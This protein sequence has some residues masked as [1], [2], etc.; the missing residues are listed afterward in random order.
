MPFLRNTQTSTYIGPIRADDPLYMDLRKQRDANNRPLWEDEP[1]DKAAADL[2]SAFPQITD[3][4]QVQA[5]GSVVPALA[6][7]AA[8]TTEELGNVSRAGSLVKAV[9][10][11]VAAVTGQA[12]NSRTLNVLNGGSTGAGVVNMASLALVAGTNLNANVENQL[13][14]GTVVANP[15]D[16]IAWQSALVGT[17]LAD[18]GGIVVCTFALTG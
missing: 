9:Y 11:P 7:A 10:I 13:T 16:N 8:T 6:A 15:G 4:S 14:L 3:P 1:D 5:I 18:P 17:G 12:T 2:S